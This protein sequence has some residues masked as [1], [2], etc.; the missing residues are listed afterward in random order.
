LISNGEVSKRA[1]E[2]LYAEYN[3]SDVYSQKAGHRLANVIMG[4]ELDLSFQEGGGQKRVSSLNG[5]Q[6]LKPFP[7]M[8][9]LP[10]IYHHALRFLYEGLNEE[11]QL[12]TCPQLPPEERLSRI[13]FEIYDWARVGR[14]RVLKIGED[15][16]N[17]MAARE[18]EAAA[19]DVTVYQVWLPPASPSVGWAVESLRRRGYFPGGL[20]PRWFDTDGLLMQRLCHTPDWEGR[21]FR[22]APGRFSVSFARTGREALRIASAPRQTK[23]GIDL[24]PSS[25]SDSGYP[26]HSSRWGFIILTE[27]LVAA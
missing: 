14:I 27:P 26:L 24:A 1:G 16:V 8:V 20:L 23:S 7:H 2:G 11:R 15:F 12:A 25:L 19:G 21:Y 9:Y 3:C 6:T 10:E 22:T 5:F 13:E 4:L 17:A 18:S